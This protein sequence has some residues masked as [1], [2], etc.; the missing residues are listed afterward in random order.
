MDFVPNEPTAGYQKLQIGD[1]EAIIISDGW[2]G[3]DPSIYG[4]NA[5]EGAVQQVMEANSL[6]SQMVASTA[7]ILLLRHDGKTALVDTGWGQFAMPD[8]P[9]YAGR[10]LPTLQA[11]DV[12]AESVDRVIMTHFHPDHIGGLAQDGKATFPNAQ[13]LFPKVEMDF[14][15]R[16]PTGSPLDPFIELANSKLDIVKDTDQLQLYDHED[17]LMPGVQ[18]VAAPGHT[19]GHFALLM[20]GDG[21]RLMHLVDIAHHFLVSLKYPTFQMAFDSMPDVAVETRQTMLSLVAEQK[22]QVLG[23]HFPFPGVGYIAKDGEGFRFLPTT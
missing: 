6:P 17:I 3:F 8:S 12:T 18:A 15:D 5:P 21:H 11:L 10:L 4:T 16:G 13:V 19:P 2:V 23:Y 7:N 20:N 9:S 14:L 22:M 1:L